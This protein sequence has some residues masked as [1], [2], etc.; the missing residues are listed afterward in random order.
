MR[1]EGI[2]PS[3]GPIAPSRAGAARSTGLAQ[4]AKQIVQEHVPAGMKLS[5]GQPPLN[6]GRCQ[7][8][9]KLLGLKG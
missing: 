1:L 2:I 7:L 8:A 4:C 9:Q 6:S 3:H 5:L